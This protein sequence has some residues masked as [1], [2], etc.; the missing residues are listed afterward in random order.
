MIASVTNFFI[1]YHAT[2]D[3]LELGKIKAVIPIEE[4]RPSVYFPLPFAGITQ[5]GSRG[6]PAFSTSQGLSA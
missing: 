2:S 5:T 6:L 3:V 4:L 1:Q